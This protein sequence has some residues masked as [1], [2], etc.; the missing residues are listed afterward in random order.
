[1]VKLYPFPSKEVASELFEISVEQ[2]P[3]KSYLSSVSAV[4][5]NQVW[6]G[7]QR[8]TDQTEPCSFFS[9][10]LDGSTELSVK[11]LFAFKTALVRPL[12][13]G[14]TPKIENGVISFTLTQCG[15][16]TLEVD[17]HHNTLCI[18]ADSIRECPVKKADPNVLYFPEGIHHP[19]KIELKTNH[20]L[21]LEEG[22]VVHTSV[23]VENAENVRI[24]GRGILD[25][26]TFARGGSNPIR[27]VNSRNVLIEGVTIRDASEWSVIVGK[28]DNIIVDNIKLIGMWRYNSDG[29]DFCN[30]ANCVLRNS[31]LRNYDDCV[32]V[33]GLI[34]WSERDVE[35]ILAENCVLWCDWGRALEVGAETCAKVMQNITFKNCDVIHSTHIAMDIQHTDAADVRQVTFEDIRVEYDDRYD[36]PSLQN[37]KGEVYHNADSEFMPSLMVLQLEKGMWSQQKGLGTMRDIR[38]R[39]IKVFS[40]RIPPSYFINTND[41][42][43]VEHVT[44]ENL[45][46][47]DKTIETIPE[48]GISVRG[49]FEHLTI[50]R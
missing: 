48:T 41:S 36:M 8:P 43:P 1:M 17:G 21:Y 27:L 16:Y 10:G 7:Y 2:T 19:G 3:V 12:S 22:A 37:E 29:V 9:F 30:S 25:N 39:D 46:I 49:K 47:N 4:P 23:L 15:Q 38:F 45:V 42:S 11:P 24:L 6:P 32:V 18:F 13:K 34:R 33:K 20:T 28:C 26:S 31:F 50:K 40:N 5:F 44:I 14:I 35:N